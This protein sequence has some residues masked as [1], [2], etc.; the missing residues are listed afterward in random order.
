MDNIIGGSSGWTYIYL[1]DQ[2]IESPV[3]PSSIEAINNNLKIIEE[4]EKENRKAN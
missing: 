4:L 3:S 2:D 1:D